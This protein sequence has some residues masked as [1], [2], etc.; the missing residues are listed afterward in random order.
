MDKT[1]SLGSFFISQQSY[2]ALLHIAAAFPIIETK[3][4]FTEERTNV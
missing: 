2:A 4:R 3:A 1:R